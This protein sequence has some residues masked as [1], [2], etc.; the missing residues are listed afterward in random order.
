MMVKNKWG[1]SKK[2][3][4]HGPFWLAMA[5]DVINYWITYCKDWQGSLFQFISF[6]LSLPLVYDETEFEF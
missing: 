3:S 2:I 5:L 4:P 1:G 6:H